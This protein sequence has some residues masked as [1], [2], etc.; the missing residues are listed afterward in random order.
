MAKNQP[1][2]VGSI[3][4]M[5]DITAWFNDNPILPSTAE[6]HFPKLENMKSK[7]W[8]T[9]S[10]I[11]QPLNEAADD[12]SLNSPVPTSGRE[13]FQSVIGS[14]TEFGKARDWDADK[15]EQFNELKIRFAELNN[16]TNAQKL[17]NFYGDDLT[18]LRNSMN[19][20]MAYMDWALIS[21]ACSYSFL[22]ANSPYL[23]G[24]TAMNYPVSAWQKTAVTTTWATATTDILADIQTTLD[25]GEDKGKYY[26]V[27]FINKTT[28]RWIRAN[29][30]IKANTISLV[31]SLVGADNNPTIEMVNAM[32]TTYFDADIKFVVVNEKVTRESLD[33]VKTTANPFADGVAVFSQTETLG[34]FE[35]NGIPIIDA[36]KEAVEDFFIVGNK[37]SV[38][39][40]YSKT[41]VKGR[42]FPVVDTFA[43]NS[44][45]KVNAVAW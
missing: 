32:M 35:W 30:Q 24:I 5:P 31:G 39:P 28:A 15:I 8:Q 17:V 27:I 38:D 3:L 41:W 23:R 33:G 44:Y 13:G 18:F 34:H 4:S 29:D 11:N 9:I 26:R 40:S 45:V 42:G 22:Q 7:Q 21:N 25:D 10:N 12:I 1:V 20:Q 36:T 2:T 19:A 16:A 14:M 6:V 37:L 43:D